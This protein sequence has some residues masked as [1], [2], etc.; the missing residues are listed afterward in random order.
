MRGSSRQGIALL[1]LASIKTTKKLAPKS[2]KMGITTETAH[3]N[4]LRKVQL[5]LP[6]TPPAPRSGSNNTETQLA[7]DANKPTYLDDF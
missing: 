2:V 1:Y 7:T 5:N 6:H 3:E 4:K